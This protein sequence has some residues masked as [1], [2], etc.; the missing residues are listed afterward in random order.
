MEGVV[1]VARHQVD[2]ALH[3][4][5]R[6]EVASDVEV[7][8]AIGEAGSVGDADAAER[9][10]GDARAGGR[11]ACAF[12][13]E[14]GAERLQAIEQ[15]GR[16]WRRDRDAA[17]GDVEPVRLRSRRRVARGERQG[18]GRGRRRGGCGR[19]EARVRAELVTQDVDGERAKRAQLGVGRRRER[20]DRRGAEAESHRRVDGDRR[21]IG[22]DRDGGSGLRAQQRGEAADEEDRGREP[23]RRT[24]R[25]DVHGVKG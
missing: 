3:E 1:L 6:R 22:D 23:Q 7:E 20:D 2:V 11:R 17:R 4:R 14:Q 9:D 12:G 10:A 18:D 15:P 25:H 8:P 16:T 21:R 24:R 19:R 13:L 5:D